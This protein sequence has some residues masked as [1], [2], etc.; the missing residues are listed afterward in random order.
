MLFSNLSD[1]PG[2]LVTGTLLQELDLDLKKIRLGL[3]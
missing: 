2:L 3:G 1:S